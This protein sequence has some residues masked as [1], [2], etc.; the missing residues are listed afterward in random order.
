MYVQR[1]VNWL[2]VWFVGAII[3]IE[4][5]VQEVYNFHV[6]CYSEI[7]VTVLEDFT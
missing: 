5:D 4:S 2:H 1:G 6:S 7:Q 3:Q